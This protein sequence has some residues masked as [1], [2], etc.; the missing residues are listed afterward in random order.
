M[1]NRISNS[2]SFK[3]VYIP[4]NKETKDNLDDIFNTK[5]KKKVFSLELS[6]LNHISRNDDII[7]STKLMN[8]NK[9]SD[10]RDY[11]LIIS[12]KKNKPIIGGIVISNNDSIFSVTSIFGLLNEMLIQRFRR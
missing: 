10:V 6:R 5:A 3:R 9:K 2:L 11:E 1:I 8:D 12:D 4:E 7:L